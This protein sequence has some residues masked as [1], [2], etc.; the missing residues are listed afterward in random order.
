MALL[1]L[2]LLGLLLA[3]QGGQALVPPSELKREWGLHGVRGGQPGW[4]SGVGGAGGL[5]APQAVLDRGMLD[6]PGWGVAQLL[7]GGG[8]CSL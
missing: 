8:D 5:A 2:P 1:P 6:P 4:G 7:I 3:W